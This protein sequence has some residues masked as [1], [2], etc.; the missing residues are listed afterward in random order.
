MR[1]G[2][3]PIHQPGDF[4]LALAIG[5]DRIGV[6]DAEYAKR[7]LAPQSVVAAKV[8]PHRARA[9]VDPRDLAV[10]HL[11]RL[12]LAQLFAVDVR[13]QLLDLGVFAGQFTDP[14]GAFALQLVEVLGFR[15]EFLGQLGV[16]LDHLV[17]RL[18]ELVVLGLH[19]AGDRGDG[20]G[21]LG[22]LGLGGH[23]VGLDLIFKAF[24]LRHGLG[25]AGVGF[26]QFLGH[27]VD[28]VAI[29]TVGFGDAL[30]V[31]LEVLGGGFLNGRQLVQFRVDDGLEAGALVGGL[32]GLVAVGLALGREALDVLLTVLVA[33]EGHPR[34]HDQNDR[35]DHENDQR[36]LKSLVFASG[37]GRESSS[38]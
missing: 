4:D 24:R 5:F 25:G 21:V 1:F 20:L 15:V 12:F 14:R 2:Q 38:P 23:L 7:S 35:E 36:D 34:G 29:V 27:A 28:Q 13:Q 9:L 3:V 33:A 32:A 6:V 30:A 22:E 11:V 8:D 18:D 31:R 19:F 26:A 37:H 17:V 10:G 16:R